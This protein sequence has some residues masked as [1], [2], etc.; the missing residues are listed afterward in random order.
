[1][2]KEIKAGKK[3]NGQRGLERMLGNKS[4]LVHIRK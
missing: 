1:M 2:E 4:D 3:Y